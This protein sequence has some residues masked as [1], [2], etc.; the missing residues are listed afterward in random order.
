MEKI[1]TERN[2]INDDNYLHNKS[3]GFDPTNLLAI[4]LGIC[5]LVVAS[6][7]AYWV[8]EQFNQLW[9]KPESVQLVK[10]FV[11]F[12]DKYQSEVLLNQ[13][14][15]VLTLPASVSV[16]LGIVVVVIVLSLVVRICFGLLKHGLKL[17][18][19]NH[20]REFIRSS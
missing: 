12:A 20:Y 10:L 17:F 19:P 13:G 11:E 8:Y 2:S 5:L 7:L 16:F 1:A 14:E 3:A 9:T 18:F 6:F 4:F 15:K